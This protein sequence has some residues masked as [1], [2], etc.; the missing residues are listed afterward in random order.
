MAKG[1]GIL[2]NGRSK[3][4]K[5]FVKIDFSIVTHPRF[6]A[7]SG[8][9]VKVLIAIIS[10]HNGRNNGEIVFPTRYFGMDLGKNAVN[11]A[12]KELVAAGFITIETR[13]SFHMKA[14]RAQEYAIA[15][16]PVG[17]R[18][19]TLGWLK[20]AITKI[21]IGPADGTDGPAGG[22]MARPKAA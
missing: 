15:W 5:H 20:V 19:P 18:P 16:L 22:T 10:K 7:L 11:A 12:I 9:A 17:N 1:Q 13:S 6:L 2:P 14:R 4:K 21:N 3:P 8:N